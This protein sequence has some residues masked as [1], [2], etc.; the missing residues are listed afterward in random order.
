MDHDRTDDHEKI[1]NYCSLTGK[2]SSEFFMDAHIMFD[3]EDLWYVNLSDELRS[4][5]LL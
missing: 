5:F 4:F 2:D 1:M 3:H